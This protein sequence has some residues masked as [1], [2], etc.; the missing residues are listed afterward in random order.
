MRTK[1][2]GPF[3]FGVSWAADG[4]WDWKSDVGDEHSD[5]VSVA[6]CVRAG[7]P[8]LWR[9]T[10]GPLSLSVLVAPRRAPP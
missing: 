1:R 9:L 3:L 5:Y 10:L 2:I 6:R 4:K 7:Y 8:P